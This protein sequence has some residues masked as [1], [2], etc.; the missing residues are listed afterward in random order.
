M[1]MLALETRMEL[2]F[3]MHILVLRF[4]IL[5]TPSSGYYGRQ[6]SRHLFTGCELRAEKISTWWYFFLLVAVNSLPNAKGI[7]PEGVIM[8]LLIIFHDFDLVRI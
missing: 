7:A 8:Q 1:G 4:S 5:V 6:T 2:D 3:R